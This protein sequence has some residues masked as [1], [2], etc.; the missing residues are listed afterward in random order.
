MNTLN[1]LDFE[2]TDDQG[3]TFT[4]DFLSSSYTENT[5]M[6]VTHEGLPIDTVKLSET[7]LTLYNVICQSMKRKAYMFWE[8]QYNH[9]KPLFEFLHQS[10]NL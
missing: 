1:D 2:V 10:F 5:L 8:K 3:R 9:T 7:N 4:V 6:A